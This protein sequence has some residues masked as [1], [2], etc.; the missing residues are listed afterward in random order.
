MKDVRPRYP[1]IW[2]M[3]AGAAAVWLAVGALA[4]APVRALSLA[5]A[6]T[7]PLLP[8]PLPTGFGLWMGALMAVALY[9]YF[10]LFVRRR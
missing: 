2:I 9:L 10:E 7:A 5:D 4:A 8:A 1:V 3:A 6:L